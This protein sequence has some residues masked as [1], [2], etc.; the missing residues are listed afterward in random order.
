MSTLRTNLV[1]ALALAVLAGCTPQDG[2]YAGAR[3][4]LGQGQG[5]EGDDYFSS[6]NGDDDDDPFGNNNNGDDDD[7]AFADDDDSFGSDDD[8]SWG[9]D[10]DDSFGSDDDDSWGGNDDDSF[11]D[12]DD[13]FGGDDDDDDDVGPSAGVISVSTPVT[14]FEDVQLFVA[15]TLPITISNSSGP[16]VLVQLVLTTTSMGSWA[17]LGGDTFTVAG[18]TSADRAIEFNPQAN[19]AHTV[20]VSIWHEGSNASPLAVTFEG[21]GGTGPGES[22]CTDGVDNEGDGDVDCDDFDCFGDPACNN[23]DFCCSAGSTGDIS[24][25]C[26]TGTAA[27]CVCA[28]DSWCCSPVG[29]WDVDCVNLYVA[30]GA[31]CAAP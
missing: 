9:G 22:S 30:C 25:F 18:G 8:D 5:T 10:D 15:E 26:D 3:T 7:D 23:A 29:G 28:S 16:P 21:I 27:D 13:S 11:G 6:G 12:D 19:G 4:P 14:D 17:I 2:W 1:L 31:T 20:E 24:G